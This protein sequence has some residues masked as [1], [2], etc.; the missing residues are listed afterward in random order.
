MEIDMPERVSFDSN[1]AFDQGW[2]IFDCDGSENGPWQLQKLD[3][4]DRLRNDLEAWRLVVDYAN[5]GSEYHKKAL[6]F[7]ADHNPIEH[8]CIIDTISKK[9]V[10]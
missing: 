7:L 4:S 3:E 8:R 10:A 9:A 6:Q 5:A 1:I 2:G